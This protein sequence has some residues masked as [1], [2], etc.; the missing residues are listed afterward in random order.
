MSSEPIYMILDPQDPTHTTVQ[1]LEIWNNY[2]Q[3]LKRFHEVKKDYSSCTCPLKKELARRIIYV[4]KDTNKLRIPR[5]DQV[6]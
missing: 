4:S 2:D 6:A 3:G 1:I 5:S